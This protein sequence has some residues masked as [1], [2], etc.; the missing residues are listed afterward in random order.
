M[1]W[2]YAGPSG[3]RKWN[4][5]RSDGKRMVRQ[6]RAHGAL[7]IFYMRVARC[8]VQEL[9]LVRYPMTQEEQH[10]VLANLRAIS[11]RLI[12]ELTPREQQV[13][14]DGF[15]LR[16]DLDTDEE[17]AESERWLERLRSMADR[18]Q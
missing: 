1:S 6:Q 14:R 16:D 10:D 12:D 5:I 15:G 9:R 13:L 4:S 3:K 2:A 8:H 11:K 7:F 18:N 17:F